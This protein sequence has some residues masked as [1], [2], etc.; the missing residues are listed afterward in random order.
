M[1]LVIDSKISATEEK[2][3][4]L[5][6]PRITRLCRKFKFNEMESEIAIYA[7]VMQSC[8]DDPIRKDEFGLDPLRLCQ[9]LNIS[10][11]VML[12]FLDKDRTHMEQGFFPDIEVNYLLNSNIIYDVDFYK[13]LMGLHLKTQEFLKIEQTQLADVIAEEPGNEHY[14]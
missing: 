12:E 6:L 5:Y 11:K 10:L 4:E 9:F 2:L 13:A 8:R 3:G 7:L 14:R 1:K